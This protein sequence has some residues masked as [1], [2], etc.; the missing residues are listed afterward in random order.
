MVLVTAL[1]SLKGWGWVRNQIVSTSNSAQHSAGEAFDTVESRIDDFVSEAERLW[2]HI[3]ALPLFYVGVALSI[4]MI[5]LD[6][7]F[8][9]YRGGESFTLTFI[10]YAGIFTAADLALPIVAIWSDKGLSDWYLF[11]KRD[12]NINT[13]LLIGLCTFLSIVVVIGSSSEMATVTAAQNNLSQMNYDQTLRQIAIWEDERDKIPPDRGYKALDVLAKDAEE[14]ANLEATQRG[15]KGPNYDRFTAAAANY[16]SRASDAK[17]KEKLSDNIKMARKQLA[18]GVEGTARTNGD[19]LADAINVVTIGNVS[20]KA[21]QEW[22]LTFILMICV[23]TCTAAWMQV[24]DQVKK[25]ALVELKRRGA[26]ADQ[27]R[28]LQGLPP[29]YGPGVAGIDLA[30]EENPP[31]PAGLIESHPPPE[32]EVKDADP[33]T[34]DQIIANLSPGEMKQKLRDDAALVAVDKLFGTLLVPA[35]NTRVHV[36]DVYK[37]Y[38]N[39]LV[40]EKGTEAPIL[41]K[42]VV[43]SKLLTISSH[44]EDVVFE[45]DGYI[46]GW[47]FADA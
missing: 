7:K 26:I 37:I 17:R 41:S 4:L 16:R 25:A 31:E 30:E 9:W 11:E 2:P 19:P 28:V 45:L 39:K 46:I 32:E 5:M 13:W 23:I 35:E 40:E 47:G 15:G 24:A 33:I 3:R 27:Q 8:G 6:V 38:R 21:A 22:G 44:R 43:I 10:I 1:I 34:M 20:Q 18:S 36:N 29:K 12:R 14:K 42:Q